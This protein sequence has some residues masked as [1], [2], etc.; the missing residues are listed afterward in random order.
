MVI[1]ASGSIDVGEKHSGSRIELKQQ[2]FAGAGWVDWHVRL[3]HYDLKLSFLVR[4]S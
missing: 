2:E 3:S 1:N 4:V